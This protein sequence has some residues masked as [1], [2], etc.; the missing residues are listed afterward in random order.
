[1]DSCAQS[2]LEVVLT[3]TIQLP[4]SH[5]YHFLNRRLEAAW[6]AVLSG[7]KKAGLVFDVVERREWLRRVVE[8]GPE[9]C[10]A[11]KLTEFYMGRLG[12][13]EER[14]QMQFDVTETSKLSATVGGFGGINEGMVQKWGQR[15]MES[16]FLKK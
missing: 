7:L 5:V 4:P 2:I 15:W 14:G 13:E 11:A 10:P 16:G 9:K 8:A 6:P 3:P 12:G 1:V